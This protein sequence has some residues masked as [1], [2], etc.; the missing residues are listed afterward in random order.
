MKKAVHARPAEG[1]FAP[2]KPGSPILSSDGQAIDLLSTGGLNPVPRD[3]LPAWFF[4][5]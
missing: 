3:C 2:F 4:R 5:R 1:K